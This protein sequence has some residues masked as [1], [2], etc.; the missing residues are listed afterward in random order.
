MLKLEI[1]TKLTPEKATE[2]LKS[3]FG[4]GGLGLEIT[5][6]AP[7]CLYFEGGGGF[8]RATV[9]PEEKDTRIDIETQEWEY[10]VKKFSSSLS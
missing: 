5:D 6:D 9:C 3:F 4:K 8:V 7:Q 10:Q 2:R 1:R